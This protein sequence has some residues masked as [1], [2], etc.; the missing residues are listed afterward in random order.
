MTD[1]RFAVAFTIPFDIPA[2]QVPSIDDAPILLAVEAGLDASAEDYDTS[3]LD[4]EMLKKV[5]IIRDRYVPRKTALN[6]WIVGDTAGGGSVVIN[7]G[8]DGREK[9]YKLAGEL[10]DAW[11]ETND[12]N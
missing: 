1:V 12:T 6:N 7:L 10:S 8:P 2:N 11:K 9:A 3:Q 5:P 4:T